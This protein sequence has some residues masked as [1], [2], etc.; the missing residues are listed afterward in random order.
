MVGSGSRRRH[1]LNSFDETPVTTLITRRATI[2]FR[3]RLLVFFPLRAMAFA[4]CCG[5]DWIALFSVAID[6][7]V[8][9]GRRST[10]RAL[11][12][13]QRLDMTALEAFSLFF[14]S[15][16]PSFFLLACGLASFGCFAMGRPTY[17]PRLSDWE[18]NCIGKAGRFIKGNEWGDGGFLEQIRLA[19]CREGEGKVSSVCMRS[20]D[21]DDDGR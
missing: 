17:H 8:M 16:L 4:V 21:R 13:G 10:A 19:F 18:D 9:A 11:Q 5:L 1:G 2:F 12:W 14:F 3:E 20:I 7:R 15:F 6:L